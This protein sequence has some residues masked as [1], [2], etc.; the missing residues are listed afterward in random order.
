MKYSLAWR[1][2]PLLHV[3]IWINYRTDLSFTSFHLSRT[4]N[5]E[6]TNGYYSDSQRGTR[7][8]I[9]RPCYTKSLLFWIF[10]M[11]FIYN[12]IHKWNEIISMKNVVWRISW[13][14]L[15]LNLLAQGK[16][17]PGWFYSWDCLFKNVKILFIESCW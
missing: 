16:V 12:Y 5:Q 14:G 11:Y 1:Y 17:Y 2:I 9:V 10:F 6:G 3:F 7:W 8:S 4:T 15:I 13:T